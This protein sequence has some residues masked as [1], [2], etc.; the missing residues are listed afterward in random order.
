MTLRR[1]IGQAILASLLAA[2]L[3][4]GVA[5]AS[6]AQAAPGLPPGFAAQTVFSGLSAPVNV[7]FAQDGRVFVAQKNGVI[8]VFDSLTD[9]AAD[10]FADLSGKVHNYWDRGL[11]G[12]ALAPGFPSDPYVYV[13]YTYDAKPGGTSPAWGDV[14]PDPPGATNNGCVVTGRLSR[15][16]AAGNHQTGP[17]EVL[18]TDWC[19]QFPSHSIGDLKFGADGSLYASAGDGAS[20]TFTDYGQRGN[21]CGDPGGTAP[22]PP[23]AQ[24]G[25]LRSQDIRATADPTGLDGTVIRINPATG[26][27]LAGNPYFSSADANAKRIW[28]Y[29]LRNP[30]RL[31][32]RPGTSEV[33]AGDVGWNTWEEINRLAPGHNAGWPCLEGPGRQPGYDGANLNLCESLYVSGGDTQPYFAYRH[34]QPVISGEACDFDGSSVSGL[35]FHPGQ[36]NYPAEYAKALF[37]ADY[38]RNCVW[39]MKAGANGLPDTSQVA[40]FASGIGGPV[41]LA[42]GPGGELYFPDINT[43]TIQRIRYFASGKPPVASFTTDKTF[44]PLPLTVQFDASGSSDPEGGALTYSWDFQSDGTVDSTAKTPGHAYQTG[45]K[46]IAKL[47]VRDPDGL[48]ASTT[49]EIY[50]GEAPPAA[51][52]DSPG[53]QLRWRSGDVI[54]FNGHATDQQDGSLPGSALNWSVLLFHCEGGDCHLHEVQNTTGASGSFSVPSHGY[55]SYVELALTATDSAGLQDTSTVRLDP[56][57]TDVTFDTVPSGLELV[58]GAVSAVTPF[59]RTMVIKSGESI[60]APTPQTRN[61]V[62][63][64]FQGW[65]DGGAQSHTLTV[66][67]APVTLTAT[68]AEITNPLSL[69][70]RALTGTKGLAGATATLTPGGQTVTTSATG[71]YSFTGLSPGTYTVSISLGK[72]R[73]VTPASAT[74]VVDQPKTADIPVAARTDAFGYTCVDGSLPFVPGNQALSLT[75][76]NA[77]ATVNLPFTFPYYSQTHTRVT[78]DTNGILSMGAVATSFPAPAII[79]AAAAPNGM[80]APFWRDFVVDA[81]A[82]IRTTSSASA[83]TAEWRNVLL[84]GT[85]RRVTFSATLYPDGRIQFGYQGIDAQVDERGGSASVGIERHAGS[86]GLRYSWQDSPL[87]T[88]TSVLFRRP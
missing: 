72:G 68:Y 48:T 39:V 15:L 44:G 57:T 51:V 21:P 33:W 4:A 59:T 77:V 20:F 88:E 26:A 6:P 12:L 50:P 17:E 22:K 13:L 60:S 43:G 30:F 8:K 32:V 79:P 14:C 82:S 80:I 28:S 34:D 84:K 11:L 74:V 9:T 62:S 42:F 70:G 35:A 37:F 64:A 31:A 56:L 58:V 2:G 81:S 83:F 38:S 69:S 52:I 5:P 19:Q 71:A 23:D 36:G 61:G 53:G 76:D 78:V 65:S 55:P 18:I 27:G 7:E 47:T 63:Y 73:C 10:T 29:G 24:G 3:S 45:G 25:S 41:D 40:T 16:K 87:R 46:K 67:E 75:G 66:P 1:K 85:T 49:K 86:T 54:S